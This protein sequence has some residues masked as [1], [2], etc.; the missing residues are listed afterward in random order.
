MKLALLSEQEAKELYGGPV[1]I[2][3]SIENA[4]ATAYLRLTEGCSKP[5]PCTFCCFYR[6]SR[7]RRRSPAEFEK[8]ARAVAAFH[9]AKGHA[10]RRAFLG[11][12]DPLSARSARLTVAP[13][14]TQAQ[15]L[16]AIET[17]RAA[18][19]PATRPGESVFSYYLGR[20]MVTHI[21]PRVAPVDVAS[22]AS[23]HD[24]LCRDVRHLHEWREA[25]LSCV[26]WGMES[27]SP[28]ILREIGKE[29]TPRQ[30]AR[31]GEKLRAAGI[32]FTAI[33]LLGLLGEEGY[34][35]HVSDTIR[36]L[37]VVKPSYVSFS[38][39]DHT[40]SARPS[41]AAGKQPLSRD[42]IGEQQA[43]IQDG[44]ADLDIF[45]EDYSV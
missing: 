3:P 4:G 44:L 18:F 14:R 22:F 38:R 8:H 13:E 40:R 28:E 15:I 19:P 26:Y 16:A 25:G 39:L 17:A 43:A 35:T 42:R 20:F 41:Q 29:A 5:T 1:A 6:G 45:Y 31:V 36:A 2:L 11:E 37:Q 23:S 27:G 32:Q 21:V 33:V 9:L 34:R 30:L 12:G 24:V 7:F 10:I